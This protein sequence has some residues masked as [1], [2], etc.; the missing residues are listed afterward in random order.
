MDKGILP[1]EALP[2]DLDAS[3][4]DDF[5]DHREN[6]ELL[7]CGK[8]SSDAQTK[9]ALL[10]EKS[11]F[12]PISLENHPDKLS[13]PKDHDDL[14]VSNKKWEMVNAEYNVLVMSDEVR[15]FH[16]RCE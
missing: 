12:H 6:Y 2:T 9:D 14:K 10:R 15:D 4:C 7:G 5:E 3:K 16:L 1:Y 8:I 13:N 11:T